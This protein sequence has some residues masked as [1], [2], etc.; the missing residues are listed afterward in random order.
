[1]GKPFTAEE[2]NNLRINP[3]VKKVG[4]STITYTQEFKERFMKEYESGKLI[5]QIMRDCGFDTAALGRERIKSISFR[6]RKNARRPEGVKDLRGCRANP[7]SPKKLT[8]AEEL[9]RLRHKVKYLEQ[10][11]EYLKK[12]EF[13]DRQA[14]RRAASREMR[15]RNSNSSN[16]SRE[17]T[18]TS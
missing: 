2:I 5:S 1:M 13:L 3:Y 7:T 4:A 15:K 14:E 8:A 17:G 12:I 18:A 11:N 10:E 9:A 6:L 16:Q